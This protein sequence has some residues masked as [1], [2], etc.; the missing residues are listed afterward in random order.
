MSLQS[1][2][3]SLNVHIQCPYHAVITTVLSLRRSF[4]A[5][6]PSMLSWL[7]TV[8]ASDSHIGWT[9]CYG[10]AAYSD[11]SLTYYIGEAEGEEEEEGGGEEGEEAGGEGEEGEREGE[12]EGEGEGGRS[13]K[14]VYVHFMLQALS[15][16]QVTSTSHN[17]ATLSTGTDGSL[18]CI[19]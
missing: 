15:S 7:H 3:T 17:N 12:R 11:Q 16:N 10:H 18:F 13:A 6:S 8:T 14:T 9:H 5:S 19:T 2:A 4:H 1:H